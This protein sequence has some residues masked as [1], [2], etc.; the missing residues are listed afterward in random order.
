MKRLAL[1][2]VLLLFPFTAIAGEK[3]SGETFYVVDQQNWETGD[4]SGYWMW[5]G[6]GVQVSSEGPLGTNPIECHGAGFWSKDGSWG[7]GICVIGTDDDT[8]TIHWKRD[9][10][11][12]VGRWEHLSGTGKYAGMT[13]GGTY[14]GQALAGGRH[15][16]EWEGEITLA[17]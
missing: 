16:N 17:K 4:G 10:G 12:K 9:K 13:G 2:L 5:H 8:R 15:V 3:V 1:F 14:K 6:E 7:E 11:E